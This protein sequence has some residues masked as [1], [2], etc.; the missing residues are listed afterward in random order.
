M[1]GLAAL[2]TSCYSVEHFGLFALTAASPQPP[3][4]AFHF[5]PACMQAKTIKIHATIITLAFMGVHAT[6]CINCCM[7]LCI[8]YKIGKYCD[9][10]NH[11]KLEKKLKKGVV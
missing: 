4:P 1:D 5:A 10:K 7:N 6:L 3:F 11:K 9:K 2:F 8:P